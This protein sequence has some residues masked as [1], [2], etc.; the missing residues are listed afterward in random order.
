MTYAELESDAAR[1]GLMVMGW[2]HTDRISGHDATAGTLLIL[3]ADRA[4]WSIFKRSAEYVDGQP[5]AMDRWSKRI[6]GRLAAR[7]DGNATYP[8]DGPPYPPIIAWALAT[9]R[10]HPSPVGMMVHDVAGLMISIRGAIHLSGTIPCPDVTKDS[11]CD[12]CPDRPCV[13]ACPVDALSAAHA[14]DVPTCKDYLL[15]P[16]GVA[17]CMTRG[18]AVRMACPVSRAFDRPEAQSAFHMRAFI[19]TGP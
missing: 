9:E 4:F 16:S 5:N 3:G 8:S 17:S 14:Y 7:F 15:T 1:H 12:T 11:P 6:V 2:A 18:C 10:F 19:G 13:A